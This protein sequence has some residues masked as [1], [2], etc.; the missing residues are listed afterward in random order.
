MQRRPQHCC[1]GR[2]QGRGASRLRRR[3]LMLLQHQPR[4]AV[5]PP[6]RASTPAGR[7]GQGEEQMWVS[8]E[9]RQQFPAEVCVFTHKQPPPTSQSTCMF[10]HT[11]T[12]PHPPA[13]F[14]TLSH[15]PACFPHS[16]YPALPHAH[17]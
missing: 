14:P 7:A 12:T 9:A 1:H 10:S 17:S 15:P 5:R 13:C 2:R 6:R 8:V 4:P 16:H 11:L 3:R